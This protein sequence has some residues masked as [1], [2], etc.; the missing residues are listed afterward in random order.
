MLVFLPTTTAAMAAFREVHFL[1]AGH[2][3]VKGPTRGF[4]FQ[5]CSKVE[6]LAEMSQW[7]SKTEVC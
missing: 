1:G 5:L 2:F 6:Q 3:F 7:Q 4:F